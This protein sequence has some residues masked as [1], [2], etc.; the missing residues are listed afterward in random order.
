MAIGEVDEV[1]QLVRARASLGGGSMTERRH[2]VASGGQVREEGVFLEHNAHGAAMWRDEDARRRVAPRLE[3]GANRGVFRALQ[4]RD[5][6]QD[7]CLPTAR[8]S[9]DGQNL[10][11]IAREFQI[12]RDGCPLPEADRQ[13]ISHVA[14]SPGETTWWSASG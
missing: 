13:P 3:T 12:E 8:W 11:G 1:E 9:E 14:R 10:A 2:H 7:R 5:A 6:A 4:P